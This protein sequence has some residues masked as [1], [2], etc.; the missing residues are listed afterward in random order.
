MKLETRSAEDRDGRAELT[1][2]SGDR[3]AP[4]TAVLL[5]A[6]LGLAELWGRSWAPGS[7]ALAVPG[8]Q[9]GDLPT[10]QQAAEPVQL[11]LTHHNRQNLWAKMLQ[12]STIFNLK[13]IIKVI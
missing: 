1:P 13:C 7:A 11:L 3:E 6:A 8:L 12:C 4:E 10:Q 2:G 9:S 5:L